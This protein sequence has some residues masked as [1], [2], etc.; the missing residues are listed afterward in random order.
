MT[1]SFAATLRLPRKDVLPVMLLGAT[2]ALLA[3]FADWRLAASV[4]A[5]PLLIAG[6]WWILGTPQRWWISFAV[7]TLLLPPVPLDW[8]NTGPHFAVLIAGLGVWAGL[9]RLSEWRIPRP[10]DSLSATAVLFLAVL[11]ISVP[12]ALLYAG[13]AAAAGSLIRVLLLGISVYTLFAFAYGPFSPGADSLALVRRLYYLGAGAAFIACVDFYYQFPPPAGFSEQ[14]VW[15]PDVI[16]RRAQGFFYDAGMLGNLCAFFLVMLALAVLRPALRPRLLSRKALLAGC[17][18]FPAALLLSFSRSSLLNLSASLGVV[19]IVHRAEL[20]LYQRRIALTL[21]AM[22]AGLLLAA[23]IFPGYTEIYALR[24]WHTV[25]RGFIDPQGL[26]SGR[27][28]TWRELLDFLE[29]HPWRLFLG[30]GFKTL[31]YTGVAGRPLIADNMYLSILVETGIAGL[32]AMMLFS[33]AI[34]SAGFRAMRSPSAAASFLGAW[35]FCFWIG[36]LF[37]M[38]SVDVLTYWRVLPLYFA[39]LGLAVRES[40]R[41]QTAAEEL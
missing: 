23:L 22:A 31:P 36:Q 13:S 24:I 28:Q 12:L 8:G 5:L 17:A 40:T 4:I 38:L 20:R 39:V 32:L 11:L 9:L 1:D 2:A 15:L 35:I 27:L 41:T 34:L 25:F 37:Q 10:G 7:A 30:I 21:A 33:A 16:V 3:L 19:A 26:L 14:Y 29:A 6:V 18:L